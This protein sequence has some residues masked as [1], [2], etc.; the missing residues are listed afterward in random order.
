V[1]ALQ[2]DIE[3]QAKE[4]EKADKAQ[5]A[6]VKKAANKKLI[7]VKKSVKKTFTISSKPKKAVSR[8]LVSKEGFQA[9]SPAVGGGGRK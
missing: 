1:K 8:S 5:A 3:R 6:A 7:K 9:V 4:E 2:R